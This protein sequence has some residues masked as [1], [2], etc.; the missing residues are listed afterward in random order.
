MD[1]TSEYW[2]A[3]ESPS[4]LF[5][6][7]HLTFN[8]LQYNKSIWQVVALNGLSVLCY[9]SCVLGLLLSCVLIISV[10]FSVFPLP[11]SLIP[12]PFFLQRVCVSA[13]E[14]AELPQREEDGGDEERNLLLRC[15]PHP[16]SL[17]AGFTPAHTW[18]RVRRTL[19][20]LISVAKRQQIQS[21]LVLLKL[22]NVAKL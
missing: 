2:E 22:A 6:L 1:Y 13:P 10:Y 15:S 19:I 16:R 8:L 9:L 18:S 21:L 11:A 17:S 5:T 14:A 12:P 20:Y 4:F 3:H 7:P